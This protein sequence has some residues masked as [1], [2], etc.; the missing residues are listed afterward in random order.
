ML[1]F[2]DK[3]NIEKTVV[4]DTNIWNLIYPV[5]SLYWTTNEGNPR[6]IFS[7]SGM[8]WKW[9]KL[10]G[11]V[12]ARGEQVDS[13]FINALK[14]LN[15]DHL[16]VGKLYPYNP[17]VLSKDNIPE[18]KHSMSHTH[19]RGTM[20]ITGSFAAFDYG[21]VSGAFAN[22]GKA[23]Y[24]F[25]DDNVWAH[26]INFNAA[27]TWDGHTSEPDKNETGT[28]G[29]PNSSLSPVYNI[30]PFTPAYCWKRVR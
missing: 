20:N 2:R 4:D 12:Y 28:W 18:H 8:D 3:D 15:I 24:A 19:E 6:E 22:S 7:A 17:P 14:K 26:Q 29:M 5:G 1:K 9:E 27:N 21:M 25:D 30:P 10:Q 23:W 16:E 13:N 11:F